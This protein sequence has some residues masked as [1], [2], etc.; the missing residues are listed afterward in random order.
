MAARGW[1]SIECEYLRLDDWFSL[2]NA[3]LWFLRPNFIT[4][5]ASSALFTCT[6][7]RSVHKHT[8]TLEGCQLC[9]DMAKGVG[10]WP[11][12]LGRGQVCCDVARS[13]GVLPGVL[14]VARRV[15]R[16]QACWANYIQ[17][18]IIIT[19]ICIVRLFT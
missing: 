13:V 9:W 17:R 2:V 18:P 19:V 16:G 7:R 12:V 4:F 14:G 8:H 1:R 11:G 3:K 15:G 10:A 6:Q 5:N